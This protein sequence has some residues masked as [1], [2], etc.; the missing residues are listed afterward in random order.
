M[1][2]SDL[3][4]WEVRLASGH[5]A[6]VRAHG[7]GERDGSYAFVALMEGNPRYEYTLLSIPV[8]AVEDIEGGWLQPRG[9]SPH[10]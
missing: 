10:D 3:D 6:T 4:H 9:C 8:A 5:L 7:F 1:L 2:T